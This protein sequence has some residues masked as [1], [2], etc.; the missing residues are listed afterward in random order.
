MARIMEL[1]SEI[2]KSQDP[3]VKAGLLS[4]RGSLYRGV[5]SVVCLC[6]LLISSLLL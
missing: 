6:C 5:C 3:V 2:S 1:T 4:E